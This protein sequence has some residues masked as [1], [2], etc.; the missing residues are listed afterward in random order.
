MPR[1]RILVVDGS[2]YFDTSIWRMLIPETE[3]EIVV[4]DSAGH[5]V[6]NANISLDVTDPNNDTAYYSTDNG[7]IA[8]ANKIVS[9][10]FHHLRIRPYP[11]FH[12]LT[13]GAAVTIEIDQQ[14]FVFFSG[15]G[16]R[17]IVVEISF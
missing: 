7:T 13:V 17:L 9:Q 10:S 11:G 8:P 6:C 2:K 14:R 1:Q 12:I 4:L 3:F 16:N 5:S 15:T